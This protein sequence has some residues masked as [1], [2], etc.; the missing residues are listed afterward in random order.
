MVKKADGL[1][2][3]LVDDTD[4]ALAAMP[5]ELVVTLSDVS[6]ACREGLMAVAV[7]AGLATVMALMAEERLLGCAVAGAPGNQGGPMRGGTTAT[8]VVMGAASVCRSAVLA[9]GPLMA[10]VRC[11]S[12]RSGGSPKANC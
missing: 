6:A 3:R 10:V 9:C 11:R 8:S 5:G 7:E 12:R 4:A 1:A 2:V